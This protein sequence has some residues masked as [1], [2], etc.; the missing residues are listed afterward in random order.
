MEVLKRPDGYVSSVI[1]TLMRTDKLG[2]ILVR[3]G[4]ITQ[5]TLDWA[6]GEQARE[7]KRLGE[8]LLDGGYVTHRDI[9]LARAAQLDVPFCDIKDV[10]V[11]MEVLLLVP[12]AIARTYTL[13]PIA[14]KDGRLQVAMA[15]PSDLEPLDLL[16]RL[17]RLHPE[18]MYAEERPLRQAINTL[19]NSVDADLTGEELA[20]SDEDDPTS[21]AKARIE[22]ED[23]NLDDILKE[24]GD[25]AIIR[26][27]NLLISEGISTGSSD[28]HIEPRKTQ[29]EVRHRVDGMLQ[30]SRYL[31]R[32]IQAALTSRFKI[33]AE[34]DISEKRLP[35]DGRIPVQM[36]NRNIDLRISTLPTHYGE[37]VVIRI[38]D[39]GSSIRAL[40]Q[41][42]MTPVNRRR[43]EGMIRRPY[44]II[45]V[46]GPT[47]SGKTTTLYSAV[48]SLRDDTTNIMTCEDPIEYDL[49]GISQSAVAERAGLTFARQLRAI[50][51]QDPDIILVGEIRDAETAEIAFRAAMTGHL[52]L[53]TLHANDAPTSVTRLA[54]MGVPKF[55]V[56]SS[57]VGVIAQR[58]TRRV[59][60]HCRE[61][62]Y[63]TTAQATALRL[64]PTDYVWNPIGCREC[65][66]RGFKGRVALHEVMI[67]DERCSREVVAGNGSND[68]RHAAVAAGMHTFL[69]DARAKVLAG[70]TSP[71]EALRCVPSSLEEL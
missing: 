58:L 16:F 19:Y 64:N 37:R 44:G 27:V 13:L 51:R 8:A 41:L 59:C 39:K 70:M 18:P 45:L 24:A 55:L 4:K 69:L 12:G 42:D 36:N 28:I 3:D 53:S 60:V 10:T 5:E 15:N 30:R 1:S 17:T 66:G 35:Q 20:S 48:N 68:L 56:A 34:L 46:T 26:M 50:L 33:M 29:L 11:P 9:A 22:N 49:E 14:Q 2:E 25:G 61:A 71:E 65:D 21:R 38:L 52:V 6:L 7:G 31:P 57:L 67:M 62:A 43:F 32:T 63:P 47:G 54:D 40:D 23:V